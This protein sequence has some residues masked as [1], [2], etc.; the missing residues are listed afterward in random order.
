MDRWLYFHADINEIFPGR[1]LNKSGNSV[2]RPVLCFREYLNM[3]LTQPIRHR[4]S[5]YGSAMIIWQIPL[6]VFICIN[7]DPYGDVIMG[8]IASQITSLTIVYSTVYSD[9]DQR[10]HQSSASLAFVRGFHRGPVHSPHKGPVTRKM[11][12]FDDVI[13]ISVHWLQVLMGH[14]SN[15]KWLVRDDH[16]T[17]VLPLKID[18]LSRSEDYSWINSDLL[19]LVLSLGNGFS[20]LQR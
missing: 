20:P 12:P 4:N 15:L 16:F 18:W 14:S 19:Y 11:F 10:K 6:G 2:R 13:M 8:A 17:N 9:A 7:V 3:L 1:C 5:R